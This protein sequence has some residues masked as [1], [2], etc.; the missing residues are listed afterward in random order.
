VSL[1]IARVDGPYRRAN[2]HI[3]AMIRDAA[4]GRVT[5]IPCE[6]DFPYH[7]VYVDDV[8]EAMAAALEAP[9]LSSREY[10]V[11]T[12]FAHTMPEIAKI[13][14][15]AIPGVRPVL[16]PG[17]DDVPDIQT[18]FDVTKIARELGWSARFDLMAGMAA[19]RRHVES[20]DAHAT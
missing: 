15:D 20:G 16:V 18:D 7:Y 4:A 8:A 10:N 19:Y 5:E 17:A 13:A 11:G 6:P 9:V 3:G 1:R 12:G 2:C 14:A